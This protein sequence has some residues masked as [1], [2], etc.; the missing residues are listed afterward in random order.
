MLLYIGYNYIN[1]IFLGCD[2]GITDMQEN[3]LDLKKLH[4]VYP[5]IK[6]HDVWNFQ[7]VQ[8]K[9]KKIYRWIPT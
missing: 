1:V 2:K 6:C 9:K 5:G 7:M 3:V 8:Q 4:A